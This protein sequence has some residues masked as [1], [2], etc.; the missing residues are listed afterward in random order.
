MNWITW[1][2]SAGPMVRPDLGTLRRAPLFP[3][4]ADTEGIRPA[5]GGGRN[6]VR[7]AR[8]AQSSGQRCRSAEKEIGDVL[9]DPEVIAKLKAVSFEP[10]FLPSEPFRKYV[11]DDLN[12]WKSVAQRENIVITGIR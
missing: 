10:R 1:G 9:R 5:G 12:K 7:C 4:P 8:S 6:V 3:E 11:V 2:T